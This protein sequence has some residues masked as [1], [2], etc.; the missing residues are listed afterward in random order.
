MK[1]LDPETIYLFLEEGL[2]SSDAK[3][4]QAHLDTCPRCRLL[5]EDR[6]HFLEAIK[7][8]SRWQPPPDFTDQ[9]LAKIF[10]PRLDSQRVI[11]SALGLLVFFSLCFLTLVVLT[12]PYFLRTL[13]SFS[14]QLFV[15]GEAC[16]LFLVKAGKV[17]IIFSKLGL[18]FLQQGRE[19]L[20]LLF[21]WERLGVIPMILSSFFWLSI[22]ALWAFRRKLFL[23]A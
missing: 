6:A 23:G 1:C 5:L 13:S 17:I 20:S 18:N 15:G 3:D 11:F 8:L 4:V 2:P 10:R 21:S 14:H 9:V 16:L 22:F 19:I 7:S 12:G